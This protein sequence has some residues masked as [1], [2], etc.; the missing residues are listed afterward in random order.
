MGFL[1]PSA[2]KSV[3]TEV[4]SLLNELKNS[5]KVVGI[6]Q[7]R[8]ALGRGAVTR[9]FLAGNADPALTGPL[10]ELA[11]KEAVP[12]EWIPTMKELGQACGIAVGAAAAG[13]L[14]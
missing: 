8:K 2:P 11:E 14:K 4:P 1:R 3:L 12:V 6:K 13:Q 9:V 7:L 5:P 10:E